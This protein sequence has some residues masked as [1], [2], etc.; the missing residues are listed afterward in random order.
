MR[1]AGVGRFLLYDCTDVTSSSASISHHTEL[2]PYVREGYVKVTPWD[3]PSF[4]VPASS[5]SA[6]AMTAVAADAH[7]RFGASATVWRAVFDP[8]EYPVITGD[9]TPG[10]LTRWLA[11]Q[12][13]TTGAITVGVAIAGAQGGSS[14]SKKH[15]N[16]RH[17]LRYDW[18]TLGVV[19]G[20]ERY[21]VRPRF[22][23]GYGLHRVTTSLQ[24][25]TAQPAVVRVVRCAGVSM[26]PKQPAPC[27]RSAGGNS[28]GGK[29]PC[30]A[31]V[32]VGP[33]GQGKKGDPVGVAITKLQEL[34]NTNGLFAG[35]PSRYCSP[36]LRTFCHV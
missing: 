11:A 4:G 6:G 25:S 13:N 24:P 34:V 16:L 7:R 32:Q 19:S 31:M 15:A 22:A 36:Q 10:F 26:D 35:I 28:G 1:F 18:Q 29:S 27:Y 33:H 17:V 30:V 21:F 5:T 14:D 8:T 23:I 12:E 2:V 3:T 20:E 9:D